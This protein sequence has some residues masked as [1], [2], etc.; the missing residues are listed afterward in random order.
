MDFS[1][2]YASEFWKI[3]YL[4]HVSKCDR[5]L[6]SQRAKNPLQRTIGPYA[7]DAK[8]I[9]RLELITVAYVKGAFEEWITTALGIYFSLKIIEYF[10]PITV[11]NFRTRVGQD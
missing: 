9:D 1:D 5:I 7:W 2:I 10:D 3:N 6:F 8:R 11:T 4:K